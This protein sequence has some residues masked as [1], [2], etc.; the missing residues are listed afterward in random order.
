MG[1]YGS[2]ATG[3]VMLPI[4]CARFWI[5]EFGVMDAKTDLRLLPR[6]DCSLGTLPAP[7]GWETTLKSQG[8]DRESRKLFS[9]PR[10]CAPTR[11]ILASPH[12]CPR[13]TARSGLAWGYRAA[14][15]DCNDW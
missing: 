14:A 15:R 4:L 13:R 1:K 8:G 12:L 6:R 10:L 5:A 9:A 11:E 7:F 2:R 3:L